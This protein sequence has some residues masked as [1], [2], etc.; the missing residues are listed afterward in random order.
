MLLIFLILHSGT[1]VIVCLL[2][3]SIFVI[4]WFVLVQT[5]VQ[6]VILAW[7]IRLGASLE[8][9]VYLLRSK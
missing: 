6:M 9:I 5:V 3:A 8:R 4:A 7:L 2:L 1:F